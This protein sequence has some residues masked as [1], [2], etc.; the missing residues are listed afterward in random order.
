MKRPTRSGLMMALSFGVALVLFGQS[1]FAA[2]TGDDR[3]KPSNKVTSRSAA[4]APAK[5]LANAT[6]IESTEQAVDFVLTAPATASDPEMRDLH[7]KEVAKM[8]A[9]KKASANQ[10]S[11]SVV[12]S[13]PAQK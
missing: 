5:A 13:K 11:P 12:T 7:A 1:A 4:K 6:T 10:K 8:A 9:V 2:G 3:K